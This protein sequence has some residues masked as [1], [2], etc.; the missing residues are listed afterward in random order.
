MIG[1]R[2]SMALAGAVLVSLTL[3]VLA[4]AGGG[5]SGNAKACKAGG[6]KTMLRADNTSFKNQGACVSY[7]VRSNSSPKA[8]TADSEKPD[9]SDEANK[10]NISAPCKKGGWT[11]ALGASGIHFRNQGACVSYVVRGGTLTP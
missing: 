9:T 2:S 1:A 4:S 5:K 7:S 3:V 6:W 11:T 8:D 10:T